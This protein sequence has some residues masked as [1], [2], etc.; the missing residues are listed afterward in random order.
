MYIAIKGAI[1]TRFPKEKKK[2]YNFQNL[3]IFY[4][5]SSN[6]FK[7]I[8]F[9]FSKHFTYLHEKK[10]PIFGKNKKN[11]TPIQSYRAEDP[12]LFLRVNSGLRYIMT[13]GPIDQMNG[14]R[15][16]P[17]SRVQTGQIKA[18]SKSHGSESRL[19]TPLAERK[20]VKKKTRK[21]KK[22]HFSYPSINQ[23][24][25]PFLRVLPTYTRTPSK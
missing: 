25:P 18:E 22:Y 8:F 15:V 23:T 5:L 1:P 16:K 20:S 21:L 4:L 6:F 14:K 9:N 11:I 2:S 13:R 17:K 10:K 19:D 3:C 7:K 24:H 12:Y